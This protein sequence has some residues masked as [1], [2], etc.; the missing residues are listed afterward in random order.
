MPGLP[1]PRNID[2]GKTVRR[3]EAKLLFHNTSAVFTA[4]LDS[5]LKNELTTG[6]IIR[7]TLHG[8]RLSGSLGLASG[9]SYATVNT[10]MSLG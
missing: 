6:L 4:G 3:Q 2:I 5:K 1:L 9:F 7:I 8:H 10:T